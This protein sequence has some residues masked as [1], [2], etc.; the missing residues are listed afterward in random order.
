[1]EQKD[2]LKAELRLRWYEDGRFTFD[3]PN[4]VG[5]AYAMIH[6]A[7]DEIQERMMGVKVAHQRKSLIH[8]IPKDG[9]H[10][11]PTWGG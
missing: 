3:L 4:D 5:T 7:L 8:A 6:F 1:M 10:K 2:A 9:N 11:Q